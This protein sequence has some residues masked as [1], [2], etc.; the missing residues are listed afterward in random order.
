MSTTNNQSA[1]GYSGGGGGPE[2]PQRNEHSEPTEEDEF[3]R[4]EEG[5]QRYEKNTLFHLIFNQ[6]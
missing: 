2:N 3:G 4:T 5:K 6:Y 1:N